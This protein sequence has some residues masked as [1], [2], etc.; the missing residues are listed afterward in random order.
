MS[1]TALEI[2]YTSPGYRL[3]Y[4]LSGLI[5]VFSILWSGHLVHV[6]IPYSRAHIS[7]LV[8]KCLI[9]GDWISFSLKPDATIHVHASSQYSGA[10]IL[11]FIGGFKSATYSLHL[12]DIAHILLSIRSS[13]TLGISC[14]R[15][16]V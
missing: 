6:A 15:K 11:T 7:P 16:C 14:L 10:S 1:I 13:S 8:L 12:T 3:N 4:H 5:G 9:A 2:A